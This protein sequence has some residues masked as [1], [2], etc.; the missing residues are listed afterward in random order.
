MA[1]TR[2]IQL[3]FPLFPPSPWPK[4]AVTDQPVGEGRCAT[5][6]WLLPAQDP[7]S[8]FVSPETAKDASIHGHFQ[9]CSLP[10]LL[11]KLTPICSKNWLLTL[12]ATA[13][14]SC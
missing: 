1:T 7:S 4:C 14:T 8:H 13:K 11:R 10:H 9:K 6:P 5:G 12:N 3:P 2:R